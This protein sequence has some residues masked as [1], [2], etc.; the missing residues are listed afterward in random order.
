MICLNSDNI[1]IESTLLDFLKNKQEKIKQKLHFGEK[2]TKAA[3]LW[4]AKTSSKQ[5]K[6]AFFLI[7][8][9]LKGFCIGK[10][11][12]CYCEDNEAADIEHIYPKRLFPLRAFMWENFLFVCKQ[13]NT[14][15]KLDN[16]AIFS[17][18]N[19]TSVIEYRSGHSLKQPLTE[20]TVFINPREN[21]PLSI[22]WLN[23]K[24]GVFDVHPKFDEA[25][26]EKKMADYTLKLLRLNER[27]AAA[28]VNAAREFIKDL[29]QYTGIKESLDFD[30][31]KKHIYFPDEVDETMPFDKVR[32]NAL[33]QIEKRIKQRPHLTVWRELQRQQKMYPADFPNVH[34][35]FTKSPEALEW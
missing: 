26:R 21:D 5:G 8:E 18:A 31:V 14:G 25:S 29:K 16:F 32:Q 1:I 15:H 12:C 2:V 7:K 20:D 3:A 22:L 17:P 28:R 10:T 24:T 23:L 34:P 9:K 13:C 6:E 4:D 33:T 27:L 35:L 30:D 11:R 19:S